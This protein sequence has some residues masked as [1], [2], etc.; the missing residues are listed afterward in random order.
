M[1]KHAMH[2]SHKTEKLEIK[3]N[4]GILSE[5]EPENRDRIRENKRMHLPE[6]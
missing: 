5:R 2:D 1:L 3:Q 6:N 4:S